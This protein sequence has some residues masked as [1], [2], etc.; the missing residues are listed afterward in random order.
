MPKSPIT[1]SGT[2]RLGDDYQDLIALDVMVDWLEHSTYYKWIRVEADD[3]G[4]LDDVVVLKSDEHLVVRQVKFSTNPESDTDPLTWEDLLD[5]PVGKS[6]KPAKSFLEKWFSSLKHLK[7]SYRVSDASLVSNRAPSSKLLNCLSPEGIVDFEE[8][9]DVA[10]R[11]EIGHQLVSESEARKFFSEFHFRLNQPSLDDLAEG[12]RKRFRRLGGSD[13]GWSNLKEELGRWVIYRDEP[14]PDGRITLD[15]IRSAALWNELKSLPQQFEIPPDYT[16]PSQQMYDDLLEHLLNNRSLYTVLVASPGLG[17]STFASYLYR[18]LTKQGVPVLRHHYFLSM[19]DKAAYLRQDS[20]RAAESLMHD[21]QRDFPEAINSVASENPHP[22]RLREWLEAAG[23]YYSNRGGRL[24]VIVDGLDHVWRDRRSIEEL[25]KLLSFLLPVPDGVSL[26]FATQPVADERL[27]PR[28][29]QYAP[30]ESWINLPALTSQSVSKWLRHHRAELAHPEHQFYETARAFYRR[31]SGHPLHLRYTL[32]ALH[33]QGLPVDDF[34]IQRLPACSHTDITTYYGELWRSVS[35]ESREILHLMAACGFTWPRQGL[36]DCLDPEGNGRPKVRQSLQQ[37]Q[38]MLSQDELGLKPFHGS[39]FVFVENLPD[40][41]DYREVMK[42]RALVWLQTRA[43]D[44]WRWAYEWV[45][46]SDLGDETDLISGPDRAW[47]VQ[48]IAECR[49]YDGIDYILRRST[50]AALHAGNFPR[51]VKVGLLREYAQI[52][53]EYNSDVLQILLY[54]QLMASNDEYLHSRLRAEKKEISDEALVLLAEREIIRGNLGFAEECFDELAER[55]NDL[56]GKD[57]LE[58]KGVLED[59]SRL[60][61]MIDVVNPY[62]ILHYAVRNRSNSH[63]RLILGT[64]VRELRIRRDGKRLRHLLHAVPRKLK[65]KIKLTKNEHSTIIREA[66]LLALEENLD[67]DAE[68]VHA[69]HLGDPFPAIYAALRNTS[70]FQFNG[71]ELPSRELFDFKNIDF[72]VRDEKVSELLYSLFFCFLANALWRC[73]DQNRLWLSEVTVDEWLTHLLQ[74]LS[75][76][77]EE[78]AHH[79]MESRPLTLSLLYGKVS[80]V[81]RLRWSA[82][83]DAYFI[84][85]SAALEEAIRSIGLDLLAVSTETGHGVCV[86]ATD[87]NAA[88]NSGYCYTQKWLTDYVDR[89]RCWLDR[90]AVQWLISEQTKELARSIEEF[91]TRASRFGLLASVAALHSLEAEARANVNRAAENLIAHGN[92]KDLLLFG[93]IDSIKACHKAGISEARGWLLQLA[94]AVAHIKEYTDG[95]ETGDVPRQMAVA[96]AEIAPDL[97]PA[98]H[99]WLTDRED[100]YDALDAFRA[101]LR[102]ADLSEPFDLAVAKTSVDQKS[103]EILSERATSGDANAGIALDS[104]IDLLGREVL[105]EKPNGEPQSSV[106]DREKRDPPAVEDYAPERFSE[107]LSALESSIGYLRDDE[108]QNW[109]MHWSSKGKHAEVYSALE[110]VLE[111]GR[112]IRSFDALFELALRLLGKEAAYKW[113]SAAHVDGYGWDEYMTRRESAIL[114]WQYM[115][116]LYHE[117]WFEF[118]AATM[119]PKYREER[120]VVIYPRMFRRIIEYLLFMEQNEIARNVT[121]QMID[122]ALELISPLNLPQPEWAPK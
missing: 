84:G 30:R 70:R 1:R 27:P 20:H 50:E 99:R 104:L 106:Q 118:L 105:K 111:T 33:E 65:L 22:E 24:I 121:A 112:G 37:V 11:Q 4:S 76:I 54:P 34:N 53:F 38:H 28:F 94:P 29:L 97:I 46:K 96:L 16:L 51:T 119:T 91:P 75:E 116:D 5:K 60:A 93:I 72:E 56:G 87:L 95:D 21:L 68:V 55:T 73:S 66:I 14:P 107:Y 86:T 81:Q 79:L 25:D 101:F 71:I 108:V 39:L 59:V 15:H 58:V 19:K 113:L 9:S 3:T 61:A 74:M 10:T 69:A 36:F 2:R 12:I 92:H 82:E 7:E 78:A 62:R 32:R 122:C 77:A 102:A 35:E 13:S 64:F 88:F 120:G 103:L 83:R 67:L 110:S 100:Y 48:A 89:R 18:E 8:I 109:I 17:K 40:Y 43:P 42:R 117:R 45:I 52:A 26:L 90:D 41:S 47:L 6:K 57:R 115:K 98:Y 31:S 114:R 63:G 23:K 80:E 44:Y 49:S 85:F